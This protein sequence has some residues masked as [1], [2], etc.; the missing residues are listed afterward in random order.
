MKAEEFKN[1]LTRFDATLTNMAQRSLNS[2]DRS[3]VQT[4]I[5]VLR[6]LDKH[7]L[8]ME[9]AETSPRCSSCGTAVYVSYEQLCPACHKAAQV[10]PPEAP[11]LVAVR[12][13]ATR[14]VLERIEKRLTEIESR[15]DR[16]VTNLRDIP[17]DPMTPI[18]PNPNR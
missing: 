9:A 5:Y 7:R 8:E 15:E 12:D 16:S 1:V 3:N 11:T 4:L 2:A 17:L 14:R 13:F 18:G 10:E 6:D